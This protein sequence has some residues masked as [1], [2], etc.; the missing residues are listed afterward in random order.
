MCQDC[1]GHFAR[2]TSP[3][4]LES[5]NYSSSIL[6]TGMSLAPALPANP[7]R[8]P[9]LIISSTLLTPDPAY[10]TFRC[11]LR[12]GSV[13][14]RLWSQTA[15]VQNPAPPHIGCVT[16]GTSGGLLEPQFTHLHNGNCAKNS[17]LDMPYRW[18][19]IR[20]ADPGTRPGT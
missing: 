4:P 5:R 19:G 3:V 11:H 20:F 16:L 18:N 1:A 8:A 9:D 12:H 6:H 13:H 2:T 7:L 15:R 10:L 17:I 14:R